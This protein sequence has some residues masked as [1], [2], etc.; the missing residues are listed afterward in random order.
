MFWYHGPKYYTTSDW[1]GPGN[2]CENVMRGG[3]DVLKPHVGGPRCFSYHGSKYYTTSDWLGPENG[4]E[5][6][7]KGGH[8]VLKPHA[9]GPRCFDTTV[10]N[11]K[12]PQIGLAKDMDLKTL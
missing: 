6:I 1:L 12:L 11:I 5:N 10:H 3:H 8:D 7:M 2:G 9:R 4:F